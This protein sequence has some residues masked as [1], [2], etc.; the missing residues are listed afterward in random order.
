MNNNG[1]TYF[2]LKSHH[3]KDMT[4]GCS[5]TGPEVDNNFFV[6]AGRDVKSI[7]VEGSD[8]VLNLV[9]GE[10]LSAK[11]AFKN[12]ISD[13]TFDQDNGIL[14][15]YPY[16][17]EPYELSG[18]IK[19]LIKINTATDETLK[20]KG[21]PDNPIGLCESYKTGQYKPVNEIIGKHCRCNNKHELKPKRGDRFIVSENISIFGVL[22]DYRAVK[23]I[24]CE[25]NKNSSEWRVP[26]KADWDD[27]LNA[28]EPH[29]DAKD[30]NSDSPNSYLGEY[31]GKILKSKNFWKKPTDCCQHDDNVK[32]EKS[33][34][35]FRQPRQCGDV[36]YGEHNEHFCQPN[37]DVKGVDKYGFN[38]VP[39][40][41]ADDGRNYVF[42]EER[43]CFWTTQSN[44]TQTNFYTKRFESN[45]NAVHQDIMASQNYLSLRLVKDYDGN[46]FT[47]TE[48]I[49][50][51]T[52]PTIL[53]PSSGETQKVWTAINVYYT[54]KNCH[55]LLP[56]KGENINAQKF[57]FI[58]EWDGQKWLRNELR[59]GDSV[60]VK[61]TPDD[62]VDVEYRIINGELVDVAQQSK[63]E[64][65]A[66][67]NE[68]TDS[69]TSD[70]ESIN[71]R[72]AEKIDAETARANE[73][74]T[75]LNKKIEDE[76]KRAEDAEEN[77]KNSINDL[78]ENLENIEK[79]LAEKIDAETARA[80]TKETELNDAIIANTNECK[81]YTNAEINSAKDELKQ[82]I[83]DEKTSLETKDNE[84]E[85]LI[86]DAISDV[87][88]I[89]DT[90][91]DLVD[92]PTE[93][94]PERKAIILKNHD[95]LLGTDTK[96]STYNLAMVSK[97]DVADFGSSKLHCNLNSKDRPT[98][99]DQD[100][101]AYLVDIKEEVEK[102]EEKNKTFEDNITD[103]TSKIETAD[104]SLTEK[105][106]AETARADK[107]ENALEEKIKDEQKR[108]EE[109]EKELDD[110]LID[111]ISLDKENA[112]IILTT[113]SGE[114]KKLQLTFNFGQF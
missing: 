35:D 1:I 89:V 53:M 50:G 29:E 110:H 61:N 5:L 30:H 84:L 63:D 88:D 51:Q 66:E 56:N 33:E 73:A 71:N 19:S 100:K 52:Y 2:K 17:G 72:L 104:V 82:F 36:H 44:E 47:E 83:S 13:I 12:V 113:K 8:I 102:Q 22:Y 4:K 67:V 26:S 48:E 77:I 6:L 62:K 10:T 92:V 9:N 57:Y 32:E 28:I 95:T 40:G 97:W 101:I 87:K 3:E 76:Q 43:A 16:D 14:T 24:I 79:T 49:L 99:N 96:G 78:E 86:N 80:E 64:V 93:E 103:L 114:Q 68:K 65:M 107:A 20:G 108:A 23:N 85:K 90:K 54:T 55:M 94:L 74:E 46:N 21:T 41:Y 18:F 91:V 42:F 109:K 106:D 59:E 11:G 98:I 27:M 34:Y 15:V 105:I 111:S 69:L 60:I 31:A 7:S 25:L 38:I 81:T 39:S 112:T 58:D 75:V 70:L 45:S 37:Y